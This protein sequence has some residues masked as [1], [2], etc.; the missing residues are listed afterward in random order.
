MMNYNL[1]QAKVA[2]QISNDI[3]SIGE[4]SEHSLH[5]VIKYMI[6]PTS[7]YHEKKISSK[8]V[9]ICID[10]KIYEIQTK[11]FHN[12]RSKLDVLLDNYEVTI[13]YPCI[14]NKKIIKF[15]ENAEV[16]SSKKSPKKGKPI[17]ALFEFYK[18]K[19]YLDHPNLKFKIFCFNV[20][21][22]QQTIK[23]TYKNR[24]GKIRIDQVPNELLD[25]IE[26]NNI[27]DYLKIVPTLNNKFTYKD[28]LKE[29]KINKKHASYIFSVIK[30][31]G[32]YIQ[33]DKNKKEYIYEMKKS[34]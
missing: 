21:E 33:V 8:I 9:D 6:D 11:A 34:C 16:I 28:F 2:S 23:P 30:Y 32:I 18:I 5:R 25:V 4:R 27:N 29:S 20:D 10:N 17:D 12:L 14:I 24:R 19:Q 31:L 13:I 15:N 26:I 22:Y 1:K 7:I 3:L